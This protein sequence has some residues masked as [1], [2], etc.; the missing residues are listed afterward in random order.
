M[1]SRNIIKEKKTEAKERLVSILVVVMLFV[2]AIYAASA[3]SWKPLPNITIEKDSNVSLN[4]SKYTSGYDSG[5]DNETLTYTA[6]QPRN[7]SV[8]IENALA[9]ILPDLGFIGSR[10]VQFFASGKDNITASPLVNVKVVGS[11]SGDSGEEAPSQ[12]APPVQPNTP[13]VLVAP[14]PDM[15]LDMN[16]SLV[17][18]I[19]PYFSDPDGDLLSYALSEP[20]QNATALFERTIFILMPDSHFVGNISLVLMA[21]DSRATVLSNT[22]TVAVVHNTTPAIEADVVQGAA[23]IDLPVYWTKT[24]SIHNRGNT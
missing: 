12:A 21:N 20:V 18:D 24:V 6:S 10:T 17:L 23:E 13:P 7:I 19:T 11:A 5:T 14:L 9:L 15:A 22:F 16:S 4:L 8:I 2:P 3:P 1:R